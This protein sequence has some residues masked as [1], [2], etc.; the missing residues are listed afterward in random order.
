MNALL[1]IASD[2]NIAWRDLAEGISLCQHQHY[3]W[4]YNMDSLTNLRQL[5]RAPARTL[6]YMLLLML[7]TAFFCLSLNLYNN[8]RKNLAIAEKTY[9]TIAVMELYADVDEK[10]NVLSQPGES[11]AGLSAHRREGIRYFPHSE[12]AKR[13][14]V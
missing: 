2:G 8:S 3:S 12:C 4:E 5:L 7:L 14:K 1:E 13:G 9:S 10:G 6:V 11:H